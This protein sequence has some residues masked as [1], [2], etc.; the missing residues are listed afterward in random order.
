[1]KYIVS[2]LVL[3][4]SVMA[5]DHL[6]IS[7]IQTNPKDHSFIEIYNP[8]GQT[9]SLDN[10]YLADYNTYY[11]LV[12]N[13]YTSD[14][15]DFIVRFPAGANITDGQVLVVAVK[16]GTFETQYGFAPDFEIIAGSTASD[17]EILAFGAQG[18]ISRTSEMLI[19]F[20]WDGVSDLVR[21]VDYFIWGTGTSTFTDKSGVSI[22][23]PDSDTN[24]S[25]FLNDTPVDSQNAPTAPA[26]G[27]SLERAGITESAETAAGGNG[28][29]GHDE[30]SEDITT[31]FIIN[32]TPTPGQFSPLGPPPLISNLQFDPAL[33]TASDRV[34]VSAEVTDNGT[35]QRVQLFVSLNN[36]SFD[37]SDMQPVSGNVYEAIIDS[38]SAGTNV[39]FFVL[40]EDDAAQITR[41]DTLSYAVSS[42]QPG[43][44]HLLIT[45]LSVTPNDGEFVEIYNNTGQT[46][47]LSDYYL[48]DATFSGGGEFYYNIVL[49]TNAAGGSNSFDFHV[50]FPA[51]ASIAPG[52]FQTVAMHGSGFVTTFGVQPNYELTD[53]DPGIADMREALPGLIGGQYSLSNSGEVIILYEWDGQSDLVQDVEYIV[54]GDKAEAVDKSG[55]S[56]DGPDADSTPSV[57]L[58]DTPVANQIALPENPHTVGESVQRVILLEASETAIGGNGLT[59]HNETS[60]DLVSAFVVGTPNPGSGPA[61]VEAPQITNVTR[62]PLTPATSDEVT[63]SAD[64]TDNGTV[65]LV[66]LFVSLD[67]A[68]FDSSAMVLQNGN[69]YQAVIDSQQAGTLVQY[70]VKAEDDSGLTSSSS[71]FQYTVLS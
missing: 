32:D 28:I 22:D 46:I 21:D 31:S 36:T 60:E 59:G 70:Y 52:E 15:R 37:S 10:Y 71:V 17:M 5:Q 16:G 65:V 58:N 18:E 53:S 54:W 13:S 38:Q 8:T 4:S 50:R 14:S 26:F 39:R 61:P 69:T 51:G 33:P 6:L 19:L 12:A 20:E 67:S 68:P 56:I 7:E 23:G 62:T 66:Q 47:D 55:V 44:P 57:Y 48:T 40:A 64:V 42:G 2:L 34:T 45:E 9:V 63:V 1:M 30:T 27:K 24:M 49:G 11:R 25:S 35:L 3:M 43:E 29:S 41:S